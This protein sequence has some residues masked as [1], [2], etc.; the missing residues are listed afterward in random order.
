MSQKA[1]APRT[2]AGPLRSGRRAARIL[3]SAA[4]ASLAWALPAPAQ[5]PS[6]Q[7]PSS[8][9][10]VIQTPARPALIAPPP[11]Q[12]PLKDIRLLVQ[13][14]DLPA[15]ETR[16]RTFI[17]A[18]PDIPDALF[19]LGYVLFRQQ[20]AVDSLHFYT[21]G[22]RFRN[23]SPDDLVTVASD[24]ILLNDYADAKHWLSAA[25][26][27]SPNNVAI[28][29]LLGR[30]EFN[31]DRADD[32]RQYFLACLQLDPNHIRAQYNLG[33]VYERLRQP[34]EAI[35]AYKR[36]IALEESAA[37]QDSQP[38]LDLGML[39]LQ[40]AKPSEAITYLRSAVRLA[41]ANPLAHQELAR[42]LEMLGSDKE[43]AAEMLLCAQEAPE[44]QGPPF[45]LGRIYRRLGLAEEA[46][47]QFAR[48]SQ[49]AG[50]HSA[51]DVPNLEP[52]DR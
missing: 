14:R 28:L 37:H 1:G 22:A 42:C 25:L 31:L 2:A 47:Q 9:P 45:F 35:T 3:L 26:T 51:A 43:A 17:S 38:Y 13:N 7:S 32:A 16:L 19:L 21:E 12:D 48:A 10:P 30:T 40:Q 23:P 49:L 34:T 20:H 46:K 33:L 41:P 4:A 36:A 8:T 44:A 52:P 24:Y 11:Q 27:A 6:P 39:L 5:A 15:A 50:T 29:Y 18:H